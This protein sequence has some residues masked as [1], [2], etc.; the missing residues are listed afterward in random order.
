MELNGADNFFDAKVLKGAL[1]RALVSFYPLG[2]RLKE[3]ES[4][5]IEIDSVNYSLGIESI[6]LL[7]LQVTY[8]ECGG[9]SL[10]VGMQHYV[11]DGLSAMHFIKTWSEM[12]RGVDLT[13]PPPFIDRTILRARDPPQ[14]A[15]EHVEYNPLHRLNHH[16]SIRSKLFGNVVFTTTPIA[17]AGEIQSNPS[18]YAASKIRDALVIRSSNYL[19][20]TIDYFELQPDLKALGSGIVQTYKLANLAITS[21]SRLPIHDADFGWGRPIFMG[22]GGLVVEG[23]GLCCQARSMMEACHL[24]LGCKLNIHTFSESFCMISNTLYGFQNFIS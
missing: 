21:W 7:V 17:V 11:A 19:R 22:P 23:L 14:P 1:S 4:G 8:F 16:H 15:F 2:G 5:R 12:A 20:S 13:V 3:N 18:W 24:S 9:V 6:P 10:G